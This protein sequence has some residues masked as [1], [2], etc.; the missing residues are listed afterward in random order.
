MLYNEYLPG[1]LSCTDLLCV[2]VSLRK[3]HHFKRNLGS[4]VR[5]WPKISLIYLSESV[6]RGLILIGCDRYKYLSL[7]LGLPTKLRYV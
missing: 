1:R 5:N 7:D 3:K 6:R 4:S 2:L